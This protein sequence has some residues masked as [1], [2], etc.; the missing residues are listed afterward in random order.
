MIRG[1]LIFA[2][3]MLFAS[4]MANAQMVSNTTIQNDPAR[5][6]LCAKRANVKPVPFL[7]DQN[8]VNAMRSAHPDTTFIADDGIIPELIQCR[9]NDRTGVYEVDTL[10]LD[11]DSYWHLVRPDQFTP[12]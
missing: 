2:A 3:S 8:Y 11:E 1:P 7:I 5:E 6:A 10:S 4:I 12:G 9:V